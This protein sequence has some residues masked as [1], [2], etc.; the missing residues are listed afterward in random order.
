[1]AIAR[2]LSICRL[3]CGSGRGEADIDRGIGQS[4]YAFDFV[5]KR[6]QVLMLVR[7]GRSVEC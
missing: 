7:D 1:M 6:G 2:G 5:G 4:S 3:G